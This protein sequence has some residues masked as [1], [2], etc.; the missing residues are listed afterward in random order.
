MI[1]VETLLAAT[2][3]DGNRSEFWAGWHQLDGR[4]AQRVFVLRIWRDGEHRD[5]VLPKDEQRLWDL[6]A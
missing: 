1:E 2:T 4:V 6:A 5:L 3:K